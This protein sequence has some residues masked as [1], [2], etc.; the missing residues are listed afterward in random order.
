MIF[1]AFIIG[2]YSYVILLLGMF[3]LL[4]PVPVIVATIPFAIALFYLIHKKTSKFKFIYALD[5]S[6]KAILL[7]LVIAVGVNAIG[8]LG[9]ELAFD[10]LWYHA[11]FAKIYA[12]NHAISYLPGNLFYYSLMPRLAEMLFTP[13][14]VFDLYNFS[15]L[16][17]FGFGIISIIMLYK[18]SRLYLSKKLSFFVILVFYTNLVVMWLSTTAYTDLVRAFFEIGAFYY[19]IIYWRENSK[20]MLLFASLFLGFAICT[21]LISIGTLFIFVICIICR[22]KESRENINDSLWLITVS[23]GLAM[24]WFVISFFYKANPFYPLF[25]DLNLP[26]SPISLLSPFTFLK[27]MTNIFLFSPDPVSPF[28]MSLLPLIAFKSKYIIQKYKILF[29]LALISYIMWYFT[30]QTGGARFLT[31]YLPLYTILGVLALDRFKKKT[32]TVF[33]TICIVI[34]GVNISY[35]FVANTKYIPVIFGIQSRQDFL[36]GHLNFNFGDFYDENGEI[37]QIVGDD[38]VLLLN[39]HNLYYIDFPFII[40]EWNDRDY[41]YVLVQKMD[42]PNKYGKA[43]LIY[44]NDKTHVTLY[45]L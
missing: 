16:I 2:I 43:L 44:K 15:K 41:K 30:S 19:F 13:A 4:Y 27:T 11:T 20:K 39:M 36:L 40:P 37:S 29:F 8:A 12:L 3:S 10:A 26:Y 23:L 9:P 33:A 22:K 32:V 1:L 42:L 34:V 28:Y 6:E 5:N 25:S 18:F 35:R 45:K 14:F 7:M 31:S 24:P 17:H 38:K 21:K